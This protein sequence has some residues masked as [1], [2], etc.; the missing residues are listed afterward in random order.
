[1][2]VLAG[3]RLRHKRLERAAVGTNDAL[4]SVRLP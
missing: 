1:L 2:H 4:R 3:K